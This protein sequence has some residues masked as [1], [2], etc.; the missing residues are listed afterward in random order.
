MKASQKAIL[1]IYEK[2][3]NDRLEKAKEINDGIAE[4]Q[5]Q[6]NKE[7]ARKL[8][9]K[10]DL[11]I[12]IFGEI[13]ETFSDI[14]DIDMGKFDFLFDG[15]KNSVEDWA[16]LSKELIGS[17]LDASL[18]RYQVELQE[19]QASRDLILNNELATEKQK[20]LAREKFEK[21][22]RKIKVKAAKAEKRN[23]LLK[24]AADTAAGIVSALAQIPKFDFGVSAS[25]F[26]GFI[27][28][29]GAAQAAIVAAQPIP[30]FKGGHL[31]GTHSGKAKI[32]DANRRDYQEVVERGSGQVEIYKNRD[33]VIDMKRGDK[34]HKSMDSF[35]SYHDIQRDVLNMSIQS[36]NEKIGRQEKGFLMLGKIDE[37][38]KDF[39][40]AT[41]KM[42]KLAKRPI[43]NH[44]HITIDQPYNE[45]R[46]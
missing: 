12:E 39:K 45:Y 3:Y 32:N 27:A 18:N 33:E 24:I 19:A 8:R 26:A 21:E 17:V 35:L 5:D 30:E 11:Y 42:E 22:E 34:V 31:S 10:R 1:D 41:E 44:N 15:L 25:L 20:R 23:N 14:F 28:A 6:Q 7:E 2:A 46:Q 29:T 13:T 40:E 37:M 16:G 36:Q 4:Y 9:Q 38:R 43:Q